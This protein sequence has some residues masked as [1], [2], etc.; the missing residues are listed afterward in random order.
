MLSE[1]PQE[2]S[3]A[4]FFSHNTVPTPMYHNTCAHLAQR[5]CYGA[6]YGWQLLASQVDQLTAEGA[7]QVVNANPAIPSWASHLAAAAEG[8]LGKEMSPPLGGLLYTAAYT[9][10]TKR[11]IR[12]VQLPSH[13]C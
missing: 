4:S 5:L 10:R 3:T 9:H 12:H 1:L 13:N 7:A 6:A 11:W 2:D 8:A